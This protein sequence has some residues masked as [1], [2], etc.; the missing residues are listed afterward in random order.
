MKKSVFLLSGIIMLFLSPAVAGDITIGT[1]GGSGGVEVKGTW[2][3]GSTVTVYDHMIIPVGESLTIEKGVHVLIADTALKIELIALG[4]F[5]CTGTEDAPVVIS[6]KENLIPSNVTTT[7]P[8]PG[9][10]GSIMCDTTCSEFLMLYTTM[11][12]YG[13]A[14]TNNSPSVLL[15]LFKNAAGETTP[16]TNFR[17]HN[18]GKIVIEHC[19]FSNGVDDGIYVEGGDFIY[20]Y[21]T[22]YQNGSTG[23]EAVDTKAGT[24]ADL[25]YNLIYSQN[26]N[27]FKLSNT[28]SRT[29]QSRVM[30]YNNTIVNAGWRRPSVKGG[31][32]WYEKGVIGE[33]YNTLFIN[34]RFGIKTSGDA[35]TAC[36]A[37]YNYYYGYTQECV[38]NFNEPT[39]GLF[40]HGTHDIFGTTAGAND[41][42]VM[43]YPLSTDIMNSSFNTDW[44]FH[45]KAES[46]ALGKGTTAI[47]PHFATNG[48]TIK[49]VTYK[50]PAPSTYIGAFDKAS[51][52]AVENVERIAQTIEIYPNPVS[53]KINIQ[54]PSDQSGIWI[55][56]L[57]DASGK[58]IMQKELNSGEQSYTFNIAELQGGLYMLNVTTGNQVLTK[59]IL[60]H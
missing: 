37:D 47:T 39:S 10:W 50:S 24:I 19:T 16:F 31:S 51:P 33:T 3:E 20:A 36:K 2:T 11:R 14:T 5:Y 25:C 12:Y 53:D 34:D 9:L 41:P 8:F 35:D 49:G 4:N 6:V 43:N 18:G 59:N 32:V 27:A 23:G 45:L 40:A 13:A 58:L 21:N 17:D 52:V 29:P 54:V 28:G 15:H 22:T 57:Y 60:K 55:V 7:N 1:P 44:D 48:L 56:S 38:D 46:P 30:V 26:T 42:M